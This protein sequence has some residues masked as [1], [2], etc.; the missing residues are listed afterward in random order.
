MFDDQQLPGDPDQQD[1]L[2]QDFYRSLSRDGFRKESTLSSNNMIRPY[3][4]LSS[5]LI[6]ASGSSPYLKP[7]DR[8]EKDE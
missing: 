5:N 1:F 8:Q 4:K 7:Y 6:G 3:K 2:M